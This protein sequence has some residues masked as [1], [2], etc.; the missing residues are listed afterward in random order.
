[1]LRKIGRRQEVM[2]RCLVYLRVREEKRAYEPAQA[3]LCKFAAAHVYLSQVCSLPAESVYLQVCGKHAALR[4]RHNHEALI[5]R[6]GT[7]LAV[8]CTVPALQR[9]RLIGSLDIR[10]RRV[11]ASMTI[12]IGRLNSFLQIWSLPTWQQSS[13]SFRDN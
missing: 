6:M 8:S 1:V 9:D 12:S 13:I 5:Q 11:G 10:Y 3:G 7:V 2:G 4:R